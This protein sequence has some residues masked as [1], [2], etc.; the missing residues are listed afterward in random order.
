MILIDIPRPL[1]SD[2][3]GYEE[4]L[5]VFFPLYSGTALRGGDYNMSE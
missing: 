2:V 5:A 4:V 1:H 3:V